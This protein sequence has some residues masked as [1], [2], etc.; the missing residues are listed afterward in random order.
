MRKKYLLL[1]I[2]VAF[3]T[4]CKSNISITSSQMTSDNSVSSTISSNLE[5][6][7]SQTPILS[8]SSNIHHGENISDDGI[9]FGSLI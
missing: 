5:A 1:F 9:Q 6:T 2:A 7:T 4:G 8:S 3:F